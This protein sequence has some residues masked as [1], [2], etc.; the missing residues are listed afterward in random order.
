MGRKY[1]ADPV[2]KKSKLLPEDK[3][4]STTIWLTEFWYLE[5]DLSDITKPTESKIHISERQIHKIWF[6]MD[7]KFF[8]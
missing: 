2:K 5:K 3:S 7:L 6:D 8:N 1:N 4:S